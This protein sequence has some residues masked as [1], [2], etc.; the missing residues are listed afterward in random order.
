MGI[1]KELWWD[2]YAEAEIQLMDD[3]NKGLVTEKDI[4]ELA[5][6]IYEDMVSSAAD[7]AHDRIEEVY[8]A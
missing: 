3:Y 8:G 4:T 7:Q 5:D 2:A 1:S 6:L